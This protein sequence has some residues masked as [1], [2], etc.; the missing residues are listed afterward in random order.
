MSNM[1]CN[2]CPRFTLYMVNARQGLFAL[3]KRTMQVQ[4]VSKDYFLPALGRLAPYLERAC[5]RPETPWVSRVPRMM[6]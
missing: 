3:R 4:W 5:I 6:W 1:A 2:A